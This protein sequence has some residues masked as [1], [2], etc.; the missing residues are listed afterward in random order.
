LSHSEEEL[1]R[2]LLGKTTWMRAA[3]LGVAVIVLFV[4]GAGLAYVLTTLAGW[5][6]QARVIVSLLIGPIF[7]SMFFAV[8][9]LIK[10]PN[11]STMPPPKGDE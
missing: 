1:L 4:L 5:G 9:W 6:L 10:R 7:G 3:Q 8:Y 2:V 11:L